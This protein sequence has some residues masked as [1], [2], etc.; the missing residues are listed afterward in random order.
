M[1]AY[2]FDCA[3][4]ETVIENDTGNAVQEDAR[5]HLENHRSELEDVFPVAFGGTGCHN[6][7]GYEFPVSVDEGTGFD[8]PNCGYDNF[9]PF[10]RQYVYWRIEAE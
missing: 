10:V 7:C 4:C 9:P 5:T 6:D 1:T 2:R 8:C 3:F